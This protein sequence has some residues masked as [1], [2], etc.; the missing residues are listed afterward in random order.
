MYLE[1]Y[2]PGMS[3]SLCA[4]DV[5]LDPEI[6]SKFYEDSIRYVYCAQEHMCQ[7]VLMTYAKEPA[8]SLQRLGSLL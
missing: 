5:V 3:S 4:K 8:L 2:F 7:G 6:Q 1:Y